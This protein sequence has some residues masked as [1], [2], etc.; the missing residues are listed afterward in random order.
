MEVLSFAD[1]DKS[2][3]GSM[4]CG[5]LII[6]PEELTTK[7]DEIDKIIIT[8][9]Y[10]DDIFEQL[11]NMG[12]DAKSYYVFDIGEDISEFQLKKNTDKYYGITVYYRLMKYVEKKIYIF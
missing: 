7:Y 4:F 9:S 6:S 10:S 2:K 1:N 3:W 11:K 5:K 12:M 8:S